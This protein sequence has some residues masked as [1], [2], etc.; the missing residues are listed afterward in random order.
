MGLIYLQKGEIDKAKRQF[1]KYTMLD[2]Y[3]A[4]AHRILGDIYKQKGLSKK[5][6]L[7]YNEA[8]ALEGL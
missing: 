7:E 4:E 5:A 2:P 3:N 1:V 6:D 8:D